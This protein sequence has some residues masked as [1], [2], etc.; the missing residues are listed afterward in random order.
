[1]LSDAER[2]CSGCFAV[3]PGL[4]PEGWE[5]VTLYGQV[6]LIR[7]VGEKA[8]RGVVG[9]KAYCPTCRAERAGAR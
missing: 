5:I 4:H 7:V 1:M 2:I 3:T 9:E 6:G 8:I